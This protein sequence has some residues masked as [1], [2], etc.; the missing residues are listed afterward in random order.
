MA[1]G[2][3]GTSAAGTTKRN[4][5]STGNDRTTGNT[6]ARPSNTAASSGRTGDRSAGASQVLA[7]GRS[8]GSMTS[9][10]PAARPTIPTGAA[11]SGGPGPSSRRACRGRHRDQVVGRRMPPSRTVV[12]VISARGVPRSVHRTP[13][14]AWLTVRTTRRTSAHNPTV[15]DTTTST[16]EVQLRPTPP[17]AELLPDMS[18]RLALDDDDLAVRGVRV[19]ARRDQ[20]ERLVAPDDSGPIRAVT[21]VVVRARSASRRR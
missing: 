5:G 12:I 11:T 1:P 6:A 17:G 2:V 10:S 4:V 8:S 19:Q 18:R 15:P 16:D 7:I 20:C 14:P 21:R 3:G 9:A 13:P